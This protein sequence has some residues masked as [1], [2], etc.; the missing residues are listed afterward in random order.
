MQQEVINEAYLGRDADR[1]TEKVYREVEVQTV[2]TDLASVKP[3]GLLLN[4]EFMG[5][6]VARSNEPE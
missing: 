6:R 4:D 5:T 2:A 3:Q 1:R